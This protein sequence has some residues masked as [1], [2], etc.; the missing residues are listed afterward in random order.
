VAGPRRRHPARGRDGDGDLTEV[1]ETTTPEAAD[2]DPAS[3]KPVTILRP[4]GKTEE[5]LT[6]AVYGWFDYRRGR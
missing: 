1:G 3:F 2:T 4:G 6:F 5:K